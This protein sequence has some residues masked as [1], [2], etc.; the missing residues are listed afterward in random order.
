MRPSADLKGTK[1]E[2]S[3]FEF[4]NI[5][6]KNGG[7]PLGT[8]PILRI[9]LEDILRAG[10]LIKFGKNHDNDLPHHYAV[11][12]L[13]NKGFR[14]HIY[15]AS[16][17]LNLWNPKLRRP[18][19][20]SLAQIWVS[21]GNNFIEAGWHVSPKLYNDEHTH[22]FVLWTSDGY[23]HFC[24]NV[25]CPGFIQM[26][27]NIAPGSILNPVSTYNGAQHEIYLSIVKDATNGDWVVRVGEDQGDEVVIGFWPKHLFNYLIERATTLQWGGEIHGP[28]PLPEMGSGHFP[29]EGFGKA[30]YISKIRVMNQLRQENFR[31][32]TLKEITSQYI[33]VP[34]C[35]KSSMGQSEERGTYMLFGGPGGDCLR[36]PGQTSSKKIKHHF[37]LNSSFNSH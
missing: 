37:L 7:C 14:Q 1:N 31:N 33:D 34:N 3:A 32:V 13:G 28:T 8:V 9:Q 16:V 29:Q 11:A 10:S 27:K 6:L 23:T 26:S 2:T 4:Q 17:V 30:S 36:T 18:G 25:I 21:A 5:G 20:F 22:L 24:Y 35:Y 15:G 12:G 19:Q